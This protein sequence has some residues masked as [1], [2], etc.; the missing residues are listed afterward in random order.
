MKHTEETDLEGELREM[1]HGA[2]I[3]L[4]C[5]SAA[6]MV[7]YLARMLEANKSLNLTRISEARHALRLH[8][9]DSLM[10]LP[11][12]LEAPAGR[13]LD[14]GSGGGFPGVPLAIASGRS[15]VLLDSVGKK[16]L[17]VAEIFGEMQVPSEL[18]STT[19]GRAEEYAVT[20]GG[21]FTAVVARAVAPL[22]SLVELASPFLI[23]GGRLIALKGCPERAERESGAAAARLA[24]MQEASWREALLPCGGE[25]RTIVRY[26]K[27]GRPKVELPRRVGMAQHSP[28]G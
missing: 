9:L 4:S 13:F 22:A 15:A 16:A 1:A 21:A 26:T 2:G 19:V 10:A 7:D 3:E 18:L 12:L 6:L 20:E 17:A 24:G 27:V 8:V 11:E 25:R 23:K 28:L 14:L 5:E